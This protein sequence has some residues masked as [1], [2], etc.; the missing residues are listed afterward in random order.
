SRQHVP[1]AQCRHGRGLHHQGADRG[2]HGRRRQ[3]ARRAG[4]GA[5]A[6]HRR[7]TGGAAGRSRADP[8]PPLRALPLRPAVAADPPV[9]GP[10]P[11][12]LCVAGLAAIAVVAAVPRVLGSYHVALGISLLSYIALATAWM[13]FSGPT[14]YISL[15]TV[16]FFGIGAYTVGAFGE[17]LPWWLV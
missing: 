14:R 6:R 8:R 4:G 10:R 15:A 7:N 16:A 17:T 1:H 5:A 2:D 12:R 13:L 9:P 11:L 3:P